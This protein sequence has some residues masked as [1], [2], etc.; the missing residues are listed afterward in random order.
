MKISKLYLAIVFF[1]MSLSAA[2]YGQLSLTNAN[3]SQTIDFSTTIAGVNNGA[4]NGTGFQPAPAAGQL[5]SDAWAVTGW[6]DGSLAFGGTATAGDFARGSSA[7][8][9]VT[10]GGFYALTGVIA[11]APAFMVQPGGSD[12][13]PGTLTLRIQNNGTT[14]I[15]QLTISYNLFVRNDQGR[16]NSFNF[17]YSTDNITYTPVPA[18]DYTTPEAADMAGWVQ[19]GTSPSRSTTISGLNIAPSGFFY[20]RWSSAD[21]SG[22]GSRDEIAI[23]DITVGATF[24]V[25]TS[26][27]AT[28]SGKV[29]N[30][31]GKG[32]GRVTVL[33]MGGSLSE[34]KY[35][36][37]NNFGYYN[38]ADV[39]V[40]ETYVVSVMSK[41]YFFKQPSK[42]FNVNESLT[43][44]D[45]IGN[46]R[47]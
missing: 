1:V 32:L 18:L 2:T 41:S 45:F 36:T 12:F 34:P 43:D 8:T 3:A 17:S 27:S 20:I 16:A 25:L 15:T 14:N 30:A 6:S 4:Y 11:S 46:T 21:V 37:T 24:E 47:R 42:V 26:A 40:G 38:F 29:V 28:I 31:S 13:A 5:D 7:G 44:V 10:T 35:T 9:G 19:V 22:T 23:D 39:S 33:L